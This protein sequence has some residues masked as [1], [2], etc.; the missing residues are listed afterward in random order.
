M[1][2]HRDPKDIVADIRLKGSFHGQF[3]GAL[4]PVRGAGKDPWLPSS[5]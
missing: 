5:T 3:R 4:R 1:H 2:E